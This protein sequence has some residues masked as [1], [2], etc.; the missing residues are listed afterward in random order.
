MDLHN[1][2]NRYYKMRKLVE[3]VANHALMFFISEVGELAG[4]YMAREHN[5]LSSGMLH[6]LIDMEYVGQRADKW[7]TAQDDG[8]VRNNDRKK[9]PNVEWE[10]ADCLMMLERFGCRLGIDPEAA[11]I[12]K[13]KEKGFVDYPDEEESPNPLIR[14]PW[15]KH[16]GRKQAEGGLDGA[17]LFEGGYR[18]VV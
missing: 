16:P 14:C 8:W 12:S 18:N 1:L 15:E 6:I 9:D 5:K 2:I 10:V 3:P 13:M 11:L 7:V 17:E 4:A